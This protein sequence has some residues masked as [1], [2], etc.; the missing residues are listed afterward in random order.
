MIDDPAHIVLLAV[1]IDTD[2]VTDGLTVIVIVFDVVDAGEGQ[3]A[4]EVMTHVTA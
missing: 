4:L 3:A 2:G 1:A